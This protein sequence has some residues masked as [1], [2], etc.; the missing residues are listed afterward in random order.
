MGLVAD[1]VHRRRV[2]GDSGQRDDQIAERVLRLEATARADADQ[3]LAAELHELLEDDRRAGA[4]HARALH[5]DR[6]ALKR[7]GV[8]EQAAL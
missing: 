7:A 3:L 4:A 2:R 5:G 8:P 1:E 6:L